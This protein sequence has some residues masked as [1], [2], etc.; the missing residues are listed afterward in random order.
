[1]DCQEVPRWVTDVSL[2]EAAGYSVKGELEVLRGFDSRAG[3]ANR[4]LYVITATA[5]C[6]APLPSIAAATAWT[7]EQQ[8]DPGHCFTDTG[9]GVNLP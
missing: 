8:H 7:T 3:D 2:L 9:M 5:I 4:A 1:M 6:N